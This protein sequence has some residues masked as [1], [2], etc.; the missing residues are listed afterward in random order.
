MSVVLCLLI[1]VYSSVALWRL[2]TYRFFAVVAALASLIVIALSGVQMLLL[3]ALLMVATLV[4]YP[5]QRAQ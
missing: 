3:T 1:Y 5:F 4:L 2:G